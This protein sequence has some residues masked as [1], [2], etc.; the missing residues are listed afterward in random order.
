MLVVIL[1][2]Y[3][4][5]VIVITQKLDILI[6][7]YLYNKITWWRISAKYWNL[8]VLKLKRPPGI[9]FLCP[10]NWLWL[11]ITPPSFNKS[12]FCELWWLMIYCYLK[13]DTFHRMPP[14][15]GNRDGGRREGLKNVKN[16]LSF[17]SWGGLTLRGRLSY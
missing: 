8:S 15:F 13:Y 3:L 11:G 6:L 7:M 4:S 1:S 12:N 9:L 16:R 2:M 10:F 14:P 5:A 17:K